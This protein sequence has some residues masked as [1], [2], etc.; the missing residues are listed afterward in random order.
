MPTTQRLVIGL[1]TAALVLPGAGVAAAQLPTSSAPATVATAPAPAPA[2]PASLGALRPGD[3]LRLR[4]WREPDLSGDFPVD[5]AG[6][7]TLPRLGRYDIRDVPMDT[8]QTRLITA[9][10]A[11][12]RNPSIEV[13][14]MR[15][16]TVSGAVKNPGVY[17][18]EATMTL[19]DV[20]ALAGGASPDG[21]QGIV[22][23]R[24]NGR[25]ILGD[26]PQSTRLAETKMEPGD[27]LYVPQR[28]WLS[29]N[30]WLFTSIL[31]AGAI[32]AASQL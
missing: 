14:P 29:R 19:G 6:F 20:V 13:T 30:P 12:L 18:V 16:Y 11:Y 2:P 5:Q 22:Q 4:I 25:Q 7:V 1:M 23:V 10:S 15:R 27:Q 28:A 9:F 24:R 8:L 26:L 32:F 21:K 17:P 31:G 3:V